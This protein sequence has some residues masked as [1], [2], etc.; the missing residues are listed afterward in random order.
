MTRANP[1]ERVP[2]TAE[3]ELITA[4]LAGGTELFH[5]LI[6]PYELTVYRMAMSLM[7]NE[8]DAEDVAQEAF[9]KAFRN[10]PRFRRES[11][12]ST[13][14]ISITLNEARSRLRKA[15]AHRTESIDADTDEDSRVSP[16]LL[17][18]WREIPSETLERAEVRALL[19]TA[20][21]NLKPLYREVVLL[22]DIEEM[23][24]E[25]TASVL[26][27]TPNLV[28]VRLH[29]ARTMLQ[30]ALAPQLASLNP[31]RRWFQWF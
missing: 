15:S 31:K 13:W 9:L 21:E 30:K 2:A 1:Q 25:E 11:R 4:V 8:S 6:R 22:R 7:R 16:T 3:A 23:S 14:L 10:L 17:R 29:R 24:I 26:A 12:F 18:D 27:I 20:I 28:K 5:T 19:R